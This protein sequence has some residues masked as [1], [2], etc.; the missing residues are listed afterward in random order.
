MAPIIYFAG[1][2]DINSLFSGIVVS[3][4]AFVDEL[5]TIDYVW[6]VPKIQE[7]SCRCEDVS[8]K[9]RSVP[10]NRRLLPYRTLRSRREEPRSVL[11]KT[12][13]LCLILDTPYV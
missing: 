5:T 7:I 2:K 12:Y 11:A 8:P 6:E 10:I 13:L 9:P 4:H 3:V 1:G